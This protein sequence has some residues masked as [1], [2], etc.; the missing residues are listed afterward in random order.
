MLS[1]YLRTI[2]STTLQFRLSY[3]DPRPAGTTGFP[4]YMFYDLCYVYTVSGEYS[5]P[6]SAP[7]RGNFCMHDLTLSSYPRTPADLHQP[8]P[9]TAKGRTYFR[10]LA[11]SDLSRPW[12]VCTLLGHLFDPSWT[13]PK[14]Q[15]NKTPQDGGN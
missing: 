4:H 6:I 14:T 11:W 2:A 5:A 12:R 15:K 10:D 9:N 3:S 7:F 1:I 8:P 13:P